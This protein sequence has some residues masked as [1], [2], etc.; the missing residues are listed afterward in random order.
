[1]IEFHRIRLSLLFIVFY[2]ILH[3]V[4]I[5]GLGDENLLAESR[6]NTCTIQFYAFNIRT[7]YVCT[8]ICTQAVDNEAKQL[9]LNYWLSLNG[10]FIKL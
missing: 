9:F 1:M 10:G 3:S 7:I 6:R 8:L 5:V 2:K 4:E